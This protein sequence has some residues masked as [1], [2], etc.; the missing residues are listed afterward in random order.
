MIARFGNEAPLR[1]DDTALVAH[2]LAPVKFGERGEQIVIVQRRCGATK[3]EHHIF[4]HWVARVAELP[5]FDLILLEHFLG[6]G[7][8][9]G[10]FVLVVGPL[11]LRDDRGDLAL[12][13]FQIDCHCGVPFDGVFSCNC[14]I[15][16]QRLDLS[17]GHVP[18]L[19][20][21]A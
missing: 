17:N 16:R 6:L 1:I 10:G 20:Q 11:R 19:S 7:H 9:H 15:R 3:L 13:V 12:D 4:A 2:D 14:Y 18:R 21:H 8:E 5:D